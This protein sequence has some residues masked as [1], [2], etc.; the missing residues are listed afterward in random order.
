MRMASSNLQLQWR[1]LIEDWDPSWPTSDR[2]IRGST[3]MSSMFESALIRLESLVQANGAPNEG[4]CIPN[5]QL[6]TLA[7]FPGS[8]VDLVA[9]V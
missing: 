4:L 3:M 9:I 7:G 5:F 2:P 1:G 6:V 8:S